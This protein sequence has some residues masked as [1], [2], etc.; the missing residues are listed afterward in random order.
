MVKYY[1]AIKLRQMPIN[2]VID[3]LKKF[4]F[5][6]NFNISEGNLPSIYNFNLQFK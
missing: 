5:C 2:I 4:K 6:I 3:Q 1:I